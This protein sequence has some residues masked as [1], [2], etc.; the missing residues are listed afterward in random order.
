MK[1]GAR[2]IASQSLALDQPRGTARQ[3]GTKKKWQ[4]F[5]LKDLRQT[6]PLR[7]VEIVYV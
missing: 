3:F 2:G 1:N 7:A 5:S 6:T 4:N